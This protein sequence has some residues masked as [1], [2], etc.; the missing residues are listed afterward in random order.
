MGRRK[1]LLV[2]ISHD[3]GR[4]LG[5][6]GQGSV[7]TPN[8][9]RFA[10]EG[11]RFANS[12]CT[13]PGCSPARAALWTGRYPHANGV[14]G[15]AHAGFQNDLNPGER[16]FAEILRESGYATHLFGI[17]HESPD[18]RRCGY[19]FISGKGWD[20]LADEVVDFLQAP[21]KDER[22]WFAQVGDFRP[23]RPFPHEGVETKDPS[24]VEV[25]PYL[26]DI[27]EVREDLAE[28]EASIEALDRDMG[29]ILEA[30]DRSGERDDT[31]VV[32][33]A[34]HGIAFPHSKMTLYDPGI[35]VPILL[36]GSGLPR[37]AVFEEAVSHV[38]LFR[39]MLEYLGIPGSEQVHGRSFLPLLQGE[40][41]EPREAIFAEKT[42]HAYYDPM[43]CIRTSQW[44]LIAN[45]ENT[46]FQELGPDF[47]NNVKGYPETILAWEVE[48]G[49]L[50]HAPYE[51]YDLEKD[52]QESRNLADSPEHRE[53]LH[54][55]VKR[56][57]DWMVET[58][59]PLLEGPIPQRAFILRME[60]FKAL[61][62]GGA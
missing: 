26:P 45:F 37:R 55:L 12:F 54:S 2:V 51:L 44:K 9:D 61:G 6:Y 60:A 32:F 42:F 52:P 5:C 57:Y 14:V 39:T 1:N 28:M 31:L 3:L 50:Q 30:L 23:H 59:D 49:R 18:P 41:Y 15:L 53:V 40:A 21:R 19:E 58:M 16:H 56:L 10:G 36:Q 25:P 35:E 24:D 17:Q 11:I 43:R 38:D 8:I 13:S 4:H 22:P 7:R 34:D 20:T 62:K 48:R 33:T 46:P 27:P 47:N 29:F